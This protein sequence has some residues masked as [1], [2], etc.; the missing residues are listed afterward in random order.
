[1]F[2]E[3][4]LDGAAAVLTF[5]R[6]TLEEERRRAP[7]CLAASLHVFAMRVEL[8]VHSATEGVHRDCVFIASIFRLLRARDEVSSCPTLAAFKV[9]LLRSHNR[10][11]LTLARCRQVE[12]VNPLVLAAS[13]IHRGRTIFQL[14]ER[15]PRR[16]IRIALSDTL[17]A[18]PPDAYAVVEEF[19]HKVREDELRREGRP[20]LVTLSPEAFATRVQA[21]VN[22]GPGDVLIE[23]LF[24]NLDERGEVTGLGLDE[25]NARLLAGHRAGLLMLCAASIADAGFVAATSVHQEGTTFTAVRRTETTAPIPWGRPALPARI[26]RS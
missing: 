8:A 12:G 14:V 9:R 2:C 21:V 15:W 11:L 13:E 22:E 5:A 16:N 10:G 4:S 23:D 26:A 24:R 1:V 3:L 25:F 17:D 18:L 7:R 19:A 20:R 6:A